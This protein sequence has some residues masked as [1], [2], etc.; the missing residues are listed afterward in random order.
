MRKLLYLTIIL[1]WPVFGSPARDNALFK[2]D[3]YR[4]GELGYI[5]FRI[6]QLVVAKSGTLLAFSEAGKTGLDAGDRDIVLRR[7]ADG[8]RTWSRRIEVIIDHGTSRVGSP[9][10]L[11][12]DGSGRIHLITAVDSARA[13]HATSDDEGRTWTEPQD[14]TEAFNDFKKHI[15]WTH[16]DTGPGGGIELKRGRFKG[17]F[18]LPVYVASK[19][20]VR[21]G[22]I[23]SDDRGATWHA[24]G[25][26]LAGDLDAS[27]AAV[28][29]ASDGS[30]HINMRLSGRV[31]E[32]HGRNRLVS[33][34]S[35]GG[36]TWASG[37]RDPQLIGAKCH[38]SALR[39]SWPEEGKSRVLFCSPRHKEN[40]V[41]LSLWVSYDE[42]R[43][44]PVMRR[45]VHVSGAYSSLG[46]LPNG[47]IGVLYETGAARRY[48]MMS[49]TRVPLAWLTAEQ[50]D[51]RR[52]LA[53][54][55]A[56]TD[57]GRF[58][59]AIA[60]LRDALRA[61]PENWTLRYELG[62]AQTAAGKESDAMATYKKMVQDNPRD[63]DARWRLIGILRGKGDIKAAIAACREVLK[64][65]PENLTA[66]NTIRKLSAPA[67][68]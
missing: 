65:D 44:W 59:E 2:V 47:D 68:N 14:I 15:D 40:R 50:P 48:E 4:A 34:S 58:D 19:E 67:A 6:P 13:I 18:L 41:R 12:D 17:R 26:T 66:K 3:V 64:V 11:M 10:V 49:F 31:K 62:R 21:S 20:R 37:K 1:C 25:L 51:W 36:I 56:L 61:Y 63:L 30:V 24:G 5:E 29:E 22:V 54:G 38:A 7:S 57:A 33:S 43:S 45:V 9:G 32:E 39:Y 35:D 16:F 53:E 23:Y 27:E 42:G 55:E 52:R 46:R 28:Y 8:G 60:V